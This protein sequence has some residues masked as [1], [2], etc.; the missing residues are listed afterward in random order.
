MLRKHKILSPK[1]AFAGGLWNWTGP[2]IDYPVA[3]ANTVPALEAARTYR[4]QT[5]LATMWGDDGAES[6]LLSALLGLQLYG[7]LTYAEHYEEAALHARFARCCGASAQ[8]FLD[9]SLLNTVPG[10]V[11]TTPYPSNFLKIMLYQDPLVQLF[12]EDTKDLDMSR[13]YASLVG[14]YARHAQENPDYALLFDFFAAL[15]QTLSMKCRWHEQ[16][17]KAVRAGDRDT[18]LA[19]AQDI[20]PTVEALETLRTTWRKLWDSTNRPQGFEVLDGRMGA[21]RARLTTAG[22]KM[23]EYAAGTRQDIPELTEP[24][25]PYRRNPDN[26]FQWTNTM[27]EITTASKI[28][29]M[30]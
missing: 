9:I 8:A 5:V 7:E 11:S 18:A 2:A 22:E 29:F 16:A 23:S 21:I 10:I 20:A 25:L 19:L 6:N 14:L 4:V 12:E 30:I 28:D 1:T 3:I 13:H 17:A 24:T 27:W 26:S 15:A